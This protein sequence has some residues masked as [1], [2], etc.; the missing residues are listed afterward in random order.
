M[1][2]MTR[3]PTQ[4]ALRALV[5]S[6]LGVPL[7]G[8]IVMSRNP[9]FPP[10]WAPTST[11]RI[12]SCPLIAGRY[13]ND[14]ELYVTSAASCIPRQELA[15]GSEAG[16][17]DCSRALVANLGL[18]GEAA[19]LELRQPDEQTLD[20]ALQ[21]AAGATLRT[22]RLRL[23]HDFRCDTDSLYF[24]GTRSMHGGPGMTALGILFIS[25]GV[26]NHSR[27]FGAAAGGTLVMTVRERMAFYHLI[28]GAVG[29]S[30]SYVRWPSAPAAAASA[31]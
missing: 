1:R 5:V 11:A 2:G 23:G 27:A 10:E 24:S 18:V 19:A 9:E 4:T 7:A 15:P 31:P 3:S 17:W 30:T 8:C 6:A 16:S 28:F 20:V 21:D 29:T 14:G 25:G 13:F 26:T 12:G 22:Q